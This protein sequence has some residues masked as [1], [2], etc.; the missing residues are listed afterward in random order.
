[1]PIEKT[2]SPVNGP[3]G[4]FGGGGTVSAVKLLKEWRLSH[5]DQT[6][7][8]DP[9]NRCSSRPAL[10]VR[11][12]KRLVTTFGAS[13]GSRIEL[14]ELAQKESEARVTGYARAVHDAPAI[15]RDRYL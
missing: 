11:R 3:F 2:E 4:P 13:N 15:W 5:A 1:M 7:C 6:V 12:E 8:P 14:I 10:A 9:K